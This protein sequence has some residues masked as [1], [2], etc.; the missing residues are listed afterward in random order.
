MKTRMTVSRTV[1][2]L[3]WLIVALMSGQVE[4]SGQDLALQRRDDLIE[5]PSIDPWN[6][7]ASRAEYKDVQLARTADGSTWMLYLPVTRPGEGHVQTLFKWQ[8][9]KFVAT[10]GGDDGELADLDIDISVARDTYDVDFVDL[11]ADGDQDIVHSSPHGNFILI[12]DGN[13][14]FRDETV[15]RLPF[16]TRVDC[17]NIWDDV[18]AGDVDGD[19]D[20]D[21]VFSNRSHDIGGAGCSSRRHWGPSVLLYNDGEGSFDHI[22]YF[23]EPAAADGEEREHS[24]H[25]IELAD[26]NNDGRL[27]LLITHERNYCNFD[28]D[29][30]FCRDADGNPIRPTAPAAEYRLNEGDPNGDGRVDWSMPV[31]IPT[32]VGANINNL[33]AFDFDR[34]GDL[35]I[36]LARNQT[37]LLIEN[38]LVP[39]GT[40]SFAAKPNNFVSSSAG[41]SYD[42]TVGDVNGDGFLDILVPDVDGA[43]GNANG[44]YLNN[45]GTS[46]TRVND[47]EIRSPSPYFRLSVALADLDGDDDLDMIW[48]AD[49]RDDDETPT[50]LVNNEPN[51]DDDNPPQVDTPSL[52][53]I[54]AGGPFA[55]FRARIS[56]AVPD[57][58]EID[59]TLDWTVTGTAGNVVTAPTPAPLRWV[60]KLTY[61]ADLQ[62]GALVSGLAPGESIA[63]FGGT[64][65]ASDRRIQAPGPNQTS[66]VIP[67]AVASALASQLTSTTGAGISIDIVE[68]TEAT[69][70]S[71]QPDDGSGRLLVRVAYRPLNLAPAADDFVVTIGGV[72]APIVTGARVAGEMW[73][74]VTP[75]AGAAS[76]NLEVR[77]APCGTSFTDTEFNAVP[78]G[79]PRRT[80]V[81]LV[82]DT[83][84]SM[85]DDRKMESA[86]NAAHVFIDTLRDDDRI[87]IVEYSGRLPGEDYGRADEAFD[88]DVAA[89]R[90]GAAQAA[91]S[92]LMPD[93]STPIGMGLLRGLEELDQ[94]LAAERNDVRALVLLSDGMENVPHFWG[95]GPDSFSPPPPNEPVVDTFNTPP[96][97]AIRLHTISLGPDADHRLME[98]ISYL[99]GRH[100]KVDVTDS[101]VNAFLEIGPATPVRRA[102]MAQPPSLSALPLEHRL[103]NSYEHAHNDLSFQQRLWQ[104]TYVTRGRGQVIGGLRPP[105]VASA[106]TRGTLPVQQRAELVPFP[107]E[108]GL[109]YATITVNWIERR[110]VQLA[111][112][113]PPG[114]NPAFIERSSADTNTVFRVRQPVAG[115]WAIQVQEGGAG[116][117]LM[118]VVSGIS[119]EKGFLR[120]ARG[121]RGYQYGERHY[122]GPARI[123]P[124]DRVPIVLVLVGVN[125]VVGAQVSA[126]ATSTGNGVETLELHDDGVGDDD[127]PNDGIYSGAIS[128]TAKGGAVAV[129][130]TARWRGSDGVERSRVFPLSIAI[131]ELDGD[132]DGISDEDE[133]RVG[134]DAADGGDA[135]ADADG[136]GLVNWK[137]VEWGLDPFNPDTDGGG[138]SDGLERCALS[139]PEASEDD[140]SALADQDSDGLPDRWEMLQGLDPS[141]D[142]DAIADTDG[143]GI[144]NR[145]E[146][147]Y[148]TNP[149]QRD[150]DEDG[151]EDG[152]EIDAGTD[153]N[154]PQNRSH[155]DAVLPPL[156][157]RF[158]SFHVGGLFPLGSFADVADPGYVVEADFEYRLRAR[159][160]IEAI[161]GR[162]DFG[163][164][165][166]FTGVTAYAKYYF[167]P[168]APSPFLSAGFGGFDSTSGSVGAFSA[169]TGYQLPLRNRWAFEARLSYF[170]LFSSSTNQERDFLGVTAG[171]KWSF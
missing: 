15:S 20:A 92:G 39:D 27:D 19:G 7:E 3:F 110:A 139:D 67:P 149:R 99:R 152:E 25:G 35:D 23:G 127:A 130:V 137:E 143:D 166:D 59:A 77:F 100:R 94:V 2:T 150:T 103:A 42:V 105:L 72:P 78:F 121:A 11:D 111:L 124:G 48:G 88:I 56:D 123:A 41:Y 21:L 171:L 156:K 106:G 60:G 153:P 1:R 71:F 86:I 146:F 128:R 141:D 119:Q 125:P 93:G 75:P 66:F 101:P 13:D 118:I 151:F 10:P 154:D 79:D 73:L 16:F 70:A 69:P 26:L 85:E 109:E 115:E 157:R 84:G 120:A 52:H 145:R 95:D 74:A 131:D 47:A 22:E 63:S 162:Y 170:H 18:V 83:S 167:K 91:V 61:Q 168:S 28:N 160:A 54:T 49:N 90:R 68:P 136:D 155:G 45:S 147:E 117:Q 82:V 4:T 161:V 30:P 76:S 126:R 116:E 8:G 112:V 142:G 24:S 98:D 43:I 53:L 129:E 135:T 80:D 57:L 29:R 140:G 97:D 50:V 31:T 44:L 32:N 164:A 132:G 46:L 58:D 12:N 37:D 158:V 64:L 104:A 159:L 33:E 122:V 36:F 65:V 134:L 165:A 148:C 108:P 87:G 34:D 113:P 107:I 169:A 62:C 38:R 133:D 40:L 102:S 114:Q 138:A 55:A 96:N 6:G 5:W 17:R 163:T 144:R 89:G 51:A 14:V 81:T 9:G